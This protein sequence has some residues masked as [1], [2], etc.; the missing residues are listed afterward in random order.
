MS[1]PTQCPVAEE[2]LQKL[3]ELLR[4]YSAEIYFVN[5]DPVG[6]HVAIF[7]DDIYVGSLNEGVG[8]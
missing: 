4:G 3:H 8:K 6:I 5:D 2:F 7:G 1:T